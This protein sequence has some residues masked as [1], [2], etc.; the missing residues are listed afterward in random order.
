MG[1]VGDSFGCGWLVLRTRFGCLG[2]VGDSFGRSWLVAR[3]RL[4]TFLGEV[5]FFATSLAHCFALSSASGAFLPG[6]VG[7]TKSN[8]AQNFKYFV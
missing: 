2:V 8:L 4:V 7:T 5:G 6:V 3:A 1:V